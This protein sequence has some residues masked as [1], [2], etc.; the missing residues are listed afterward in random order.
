MLPLLNL[1]TGHVVGVGL[2]NRR[3]QSIIN[4]LGAGLVEMNLDNVPQREENMTA[5]EMMLSESQERMLMVLRPGSEDQARAVF[6]KWE[7]NFSIIGKLTDTGH[8]VLYHHEEIVADLPIDPLALASPE[9]DEVERPWTPTPE[10]K[11]LKAKEIV[12]HNITV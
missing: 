6:S 3:A 1:N 9:Y 10:A 12:K 4:A 7:L 11:I 8:M 5:Y 2:K